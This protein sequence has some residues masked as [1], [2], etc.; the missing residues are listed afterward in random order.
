MKKAFTLAEVLITLG[1][2][3]IVAAMTLPVITNK[4]REQIK[5][6][7][8]KKIYSIMQQLNNRAKA[9]YGDSLI[10]ALP[11]TQDFFDLYIIPYLN[12]LKYC[13]EK[14]CTY[15]RINPNTGEKI[16][17][18]SEPGFILQDGTLFKVVNLHGN[19]S[20]FFAMWLIDINGTNPP[21]KTNKDIYF[22][23]FGINTNRIDILTGKTVGSSLFYFTPNSTSENYYDGI[24][25]GC[26]REIVKNNYKPVNNCLDH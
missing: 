11:T 8:L 12:P 21:N 16:N 3:G 25:S 18:T 13:L 23:E 5:I 6:Q 24:G 2:I 19:S 15:Y 1:I 10:P 20:G 14:N 22:A 26:F 4:Y 9:E 17:M 7:K